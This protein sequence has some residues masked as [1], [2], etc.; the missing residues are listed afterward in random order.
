MRIVS[1][2]WRGRRLNEPTGR[3]VTRPTTDRVREAMTSMID[4]ARDEGI[5]GARV[6]DAFAGSG[7][8]GIEMLSRGASFASFFDVDRKAAALVRSNLETLRC[9]RE[10]YRVTCGD[11][12]AYAARGRVVGA[13]FDLVFID[14]PYALGSEPACELLVALARH[15][16]LRAHALAIAERSASDAGPRPEGFSVV[17]EKRYGTTA[18]DL[19]RLD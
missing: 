1:G 6:L 2:Q 17:R 18:V 10:R 14:A 15:G 9:E 13:P 7:A 5:E 4:S 8:L 3:D 19:L 16:L 11:V 12:L